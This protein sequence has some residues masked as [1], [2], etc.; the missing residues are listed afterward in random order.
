MLALVIQRLDP[1]SQYGKRWVGIPGKGK[2]CLP[3][4]LREERPLSLLEVT[5]GGCNHKMLAALSCPPV[6]GAN[7][8][9]GEKPGPSHVHHMSLDPAR[10]QARPGAGP[11]VM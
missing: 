11:L 3:L 7:V 5:E 1:N 4:E 6:K 10:P 8:M 9:G 2:V